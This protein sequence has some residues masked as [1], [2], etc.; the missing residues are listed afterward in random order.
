MKIRFAMPFTGVRVGISAAAGCYR[1]R[2][3]GVE[4]FG[5]EQRAKKVPRELFDHSKG[6]RKL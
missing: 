3:G 2:D 5:I 6:T 4:E 1:R